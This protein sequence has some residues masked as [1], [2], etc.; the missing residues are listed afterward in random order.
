MPATVL[1]VAMS[2]TAGGWSGSLFSELGPKIIAFRDLFANYVPL[3]D[4]ELTFLPLLFG[5]ALG[6]ATRA[7]RINRCMF[8]PLAVMALVYLAMPHTLLTSGG[9]YRRFT[10]PLTLLLISSTDWEIRKHQLKALFSTLLGALLLVRIAVLELVWLEQD[11]ALLSYR[12][13]IAL[14]PR[15]ARLFPVFLPSHV[16][17]RTNFPCMAVIDRDAFVPSLFAYENQQP[18]RFSDEAK[19]L[20]SQAPRWSFITAVYDYVILTD[21]RH[22]RRRHPDTLEEVQTN[23]DLAV[24]RVVR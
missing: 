7:V 19:T 24:F 15:G 22:L 23:G 12:E 2:P 4:L 14:L 1:F 21:A 3:L 11:R 8:V 18:I 6:I 13:A 17:Y 9:A 10:V 5:L 16:T 20:V